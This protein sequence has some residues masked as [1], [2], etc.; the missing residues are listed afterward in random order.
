LS[1]SI[2]KPISTYTL[3]E[4]VTLRMTLISYFRQ[5]C[6]PVFHIPQLL[7]N[8]AYNGCFLVFITDGLDSFL[9]MTKRK[10]ESESAITED[11]TKIWCEQR[12]TH[13]S[14]Q[15]MGQLLGQGVDITTCDAV[16]AANTTSLLPSFTKQLAILYGEPNTTQITPNFTKQDTV[17]TTTSTFL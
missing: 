12:S 6:L 13:A 11:D 16:S 9:R 1:W 7:T 3:F 8:L 17:I 2:N 4:R 15:R 14:L 5:V 10:L